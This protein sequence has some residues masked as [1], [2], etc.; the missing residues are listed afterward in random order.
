MATLK[1]FQ[2]RERPGWFKVF[3]ILPL[4]WNGI[5]LS[6]PGNSQ[7]VIRM[8]LEQGEKVWTALI[9]EGNLMPVSN[10][11]KLDYYGKDQLNQS[12]PMILTSKGQ[13]AWSEKPYKLEISENRILI[14]D[15]YG[16][17]RYGK[18]GKN[19]RDAQIYV[20]NAFFPASGKMPDELLFAAPQYNT[21][22]ELNY[23]QN[24][25][26]I[27]EYARNIVKNGFPAGVLM[28]D[29]SWQEDYGV[30]D[31]HPGRFEDPKAMVDKLHNMGFKVMLW[32]CPFVSP[33]QSLIFRKLRDEKAFILE[34][35]HPGDTWE[36]AKLPAMIYWWNGFSAELDFTNP[37]AEEW[38]RKNLDFLVEAYNID[39]FKFDAGEAKFY[40]D[41]TLSKGGILPNEHSWLWAQWGLEYP[42]NE[43]RITWKMGGQPLAERLLDKEHTWEDLQKLIPNMILEGLAG[44][45]FSCPD[46]IGGGLLRTMQD[47]SQ[48]DQELIVRSAQCHALMPMMQF[49]VA[50]WRVLDSKHFEAVRK[51]VDLRKQYTPLILRLARESAKTG[52]PIL[53]SLEYVFPGKGYEEIKDEFMLGDSLLVTPRVTKE[54]T[55]R[56][57]LLPP[58]NWRSD[59]GK[60]YQGDKSIYIDVPLERLPYFIRL[61]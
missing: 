14:T 22:I 43:F 61:Q 7:E 27:L 3:T 5:F 33:D 28:I 13:Y 48:L 51:A 53:K 42:L 36:S 31:F 19:L 9:N 2:D 10:G 56:N 52:E 34:K 37:K 12:Q 46:M 60:I 47:E 59:S 25:K 38:F 57:V 44:Y 15:P 41:H 4:V 50:P 26:D 11:Y 55:G 6:F 23:H 21:W 8:D 1:L 45:T 54:G 20:R 17:V 18:H 39:G 40:P 58:G 24:Q 35:Q 30:W 16:E 32:I 49:S 29:D